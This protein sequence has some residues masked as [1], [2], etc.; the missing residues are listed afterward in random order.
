MLITFSKKKI[1]DALSTLISQVDIASSTQFQY[2]FILQ[3]YISF[4][5]SLPQDLP[6]EYCKYKIQTIYH[7]AYLEI[8]LNTLS[9]SR[10]IVEISVLS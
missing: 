10:N 3:N 5:H 1:N 6:R 7:K 2:A 9:S 4:G 8:F